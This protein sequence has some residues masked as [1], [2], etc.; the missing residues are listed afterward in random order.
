M[1]VR[2]AIALSLA[3]LLV[4]LAVGSAIL[5][6][7]LWNYEHAKVEQALQGLSKG[8]NHAVDLHLGHGRAQL[9]AIAAL[10]EMR[11]GDLPE[12]YRYARDVVADRPGTLITLV[13]P[14]GQLLVNTS[15]PFGSSL[16]NLWRW[17]EQQREANWRGHTLPVSS[18]GLTH[19][20]F[21]SGQ[22]GYSSLYFSR[23]VN[24]PRMATAIPVQR[25]GKTLYVLML[26]YPASALE[27]LL[28]KT[29]LPAQ[30]RAVL[31]DR[32]GTVVASNGASPYAVGQRLDLAVSSA[33]LHELEEPDGTSTTAAYAKNDAGL[34][35]MVGLPR[36]EAYRTAHN[37]ALGWGLGCLAALALSFLGAV[38]LNRRFSEPLRRLAASA[39]AGAPQLPEPSNIL[40]IDSLANALRAAARKEELQ[41][42]EHLRLLEAEKQ[43][44][45]L[46]SSETQ[47]RR[48]FDSLYVSVAVLDT[49]GRLIKV[50]RAPVERA[51]ITR[52]DVVGQL[53]WDCYWW[54]YDP[55]VQNILRE[56]VA[57][58]RGGQV[59]RFD[60]P[61][62]AE[63]G[64]LVMVDFQLSP[65]TDNTG[66]VTQLIASAVM[67]QDRVEATRALQARAAEAR[68]TARKLDEQRWLLDAALEVT[69]AG[70]LIS[71]ASGR[72]LRMNQANQRL[73][74][75]AP[76][77]ASV[78]EYAAWKG[79]WAQGQEHQGEV[80][81][82]RDWPLARALLSGQPESSVIDIEPF[83]APGVRKTVHIS[84]AP[85]L[86]ELG[87]VVGGVIVQIDITDQMRAEAALRQ[88]D[89]HKDEFM[90]TLGHELRNP[91][92]P[93]RSAIHILKSRH[94]ADP[95]LIR[96]QEVIERQTKH[97]TRLV[98]DLLDVARIRQGAIRM[99]LELLTLQDV[100]AAAIETVS[101]ALHATRVRFS[102]EFA[103]E[104]LFVQG[105]A[106][107]LSQ[108]LVNV[109][110][111]AC[112]FTGAGGQVTLRLRREGATA[113]IEVQDSGI[114]LAPESQDRIFGLFVQ[115][116]PSGAAGNSGL[117]IGLALSRNLLVMH[118]GS[119]VAAS[120]GLGNGSTFT[121][122]LP[123]V[124]A[125]RSM[126]VPSIETRQEH[127][128]R[129]HRLLVVDDNRDGCDTMKELLEMSGFEVRT[130]YDGATA[131]AAVQKATPD[132]L[133]LD[134]GLPDMNGY[135]LCRRIRVQ[136]GAAPVIIALTGWSQPQDKKAAEGAGFD[137]HIAKPADPDSLCKVL[138]KY[139]RDRDT[140][141]AQQD[142]K[143][144]LLIRTTS[145]EG[146]LTAVEAGLKQEGYTALHLF[147]AAL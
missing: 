85:V 16:P 111:N 132:A 8:I 89:R 47:M 55:A 103:E 105:D 95:V 39:L 10:P 73:W 133:V 125:P 25:D 70:M 114:G 28:A 20:V 54:S 98:D 90:A 45:I 2:R 15:V 93:I 131:L 144:S 94:T 56:S 102:Q 124:D 46:R 117:G 129:R 41:R 49:D 48:A 104:P 50:N 38:G 69:P 112:K 67:V 142:A 82:P 74:G 30:A 84:A 40:E 7:S 12:I 134:I 77:S 116:Q 138:F 34:T 119:L 145:S 33:A 143:V 146:Q 44:E 35:V 6:L 147:D 123:L 122:R 72:L 135:E 31:L 139:L 118:G 126:A 51:G 128:S 141:H 58:A 63:N 140:P 64:R 75:A 11:R 81:Q 71:D 32:N 24:G 100:V 121:A 115:E 1:S 120:A 53:F 22:I 109:L 92:G 52:T 91:L 106:T 79:W 99:Q 42:Q 27:Q 59:V 36:A 21:R 113:I 18:Q 86:D 76:F 65:L 26:S 23:N 66:V 61:V 19:E 3:C 137:A 83:Q 101:P 4:P 62:R 68:E 78:D 87:V 14:D 110:T 96:A 5:V 107:R 13:G 97:M 80:V 37:A 130:A 108:A 9:E 57:E 127:P 17:Q 29:G 60:V 136:V 88:A 43:E